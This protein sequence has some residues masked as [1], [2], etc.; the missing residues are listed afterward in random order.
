LPAI[1]IGWGPWSER[2]LAA[3]LKAQFERRGIET[4]TPERGLALFEQARSRAEASLVVAPLDVAAL[5]RALAGFTPAIWRS[6]VEAPDSEQQ[7]P[8]ASFRQLSRLPLKQRADAV[9]AT[10]RGEI[11]RVLSLASASLVT[12]DKPLSELGMDSLMAVELRSALGR[13]TGV[14]L[15]TALIAAQPTPA[16]IEQHILEHLDPPS[17]QAGNAAGADEQRS[18]LEARAMSSSAAH[19]EAL[20]QLEAPAA[21]L[22]CFHDA[23][24]SAAMF[25]PL[26]QL[27]QAG[28]EVH[29]I[30]HT[31]RAPASAEAA[32]QYLREATDYVRRLADRP[33]V[34]FGH[35]LGG[36]IAW[37]LGQELVASGSSPAL[38]CVSGID[39]TRLSGSLPDSA[40]D[41][42]FAEIFGARAAE[43]H[44]LKQDFNADMQLWRAMPSDSGLPA[45][46]P[47]PIDAF[48]G[49]DDQV[50][51]EISM[52]GWSARTNSDFSLTVL[53]GNHFYLGQEPAQRLLIGALASRIHAQLSRGTILAANNHRTRSTTQFW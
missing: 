25:L 3:G 27:A 17:P 51:T 5:T 40:L 45:S 39:P 44:N 4:I 33:C 53:R 8:H 12:P 49:R 13:T 37:R 43:A 18:Q 52:G 1:S 31:R 29:A 34:L 24:G 9:A 50:A 20:N 21:R 19:G 10:V 42:A 32:Q 28:V 26:R 2:G 48:V 46:L 22:F 35:S 11:A 14:H 7:P 16:V 23:G 6:L 41:A 15:P 36:L 47:I 38:L 30:S